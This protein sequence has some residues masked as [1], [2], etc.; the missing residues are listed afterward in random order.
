MVHGV[1]LVTPSGRLLEGRF[2]TSIRRHGDFFA[3]N[4]PGQMY[5]RAWNCSNLIENLWKAYVDFESN[6]DRERAI[7]LFEKLLERTKNVKEWLS[8]AMFEA[9]T[10]DGENLLKNEMQCIQRAQNVFERAVDYFRISASELKEDRAML[11][12]EWLRTE[13]SSGEIGDIDLVAAK[14]PLKVKKRRLIKTED[15]SG[16][17]ES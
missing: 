4:R 10:D 14:Q 6:N 8:Y 13:K 3:R 1:Y 16:G 5:F 2:L 17:Y 9:F 11:L 15:G 7:D 12:E